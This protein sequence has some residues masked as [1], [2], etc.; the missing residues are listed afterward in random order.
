MPWLRLDAEGS[1]SRPWAQSVAAHLK[2]ELASRGISLCLAPAREDAAAPLAVVE[3]R[4]GE[5]NLLDVA[6]ED[7]ATG[8]RLTRQVAL[9]GIPLDA[10]PLGIALAADELLRASWLEA[11]M[12]QAQVAREPLAPQATDAVK[13]GANESLNVPVRA[14]SARAWLSVLGAGEHSTGGQSFGGFDARAGWGGNVE[15]AGRV[16]Y[17]V[18]ASVS[19]AHGSIESSALLGGVS[20]G[21]SIARPEASWGAE[22]FLRGDVDRIAFVGQAATGATGG[23]GSAVA[24]L[25]GGGASAWLS[26][27]RAWRLV[28]EISLAAAIRP[29]AAVDAGEEAS[30]LS[31]AIVG[32]AFGVA[33]GL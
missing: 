3:L 12:E 1:L 21:Y 31:G 6:I 28:G 33:A 14:P 11:S 30:S 5:P 19:A 25:A 18:G 24:L 13:G 15:I 27:G 22:V 2:L 17:R 23:A 9:D 32:V 26:P 8:K 29:V 7:P 4:L 20:L 16:G 10:R